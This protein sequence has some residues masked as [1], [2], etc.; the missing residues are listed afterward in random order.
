M[1]MR[2]DKKFLALDMP[3]PQ[4][5]IFLFG[6]PRIVQVG[7]PLKLERRRTLALFAYLAL[8]GPC[9]RDNLVAFFW[10]DSSPDQAGAYLRH[11][12]WEISK[13]IGDGWL[14]KDGPLVG[15]NYAA[16]IWCDAYEI[17][18]L[19]ADNPNLDLSMASRIAALEKDDFL[20]GFTLKD[21]YEFDDWQAAR[22]EWFRQKLSQ[23]LESLAT[24]ESGRGGLED[25][26]VYAH[27]RLALDPLDESSHR[28]LMRILDRSGQRSAAL[29]Q[30]E[31]C[32]RLLNDQ[33]GVTPEAETTLL[34]RQIQAGQ[35]N[36]PE[37]ATRP[38]PLTRPPVPVYLPLQSTPFIGRQSE[39]DQIRAT[40]ANPEC[41]LLVLSGPGGSGKTRLAIQAAGLCAASLAT[42]LFTD[43]IYFCPF[44][45][46]TDPQQIPDR[47]A[48]ALRLQLQRKSLN[49]LNPDQTFEQVRA[50]LSEKSILL[51]IDNFEQLAGQCS[52]LFDLLAAAPNLKII[53][54]S[55]ER[56]NL[57]GEWGLEVAGFPLPGGDQ[58]EAL[59][60]NPAVEMFLKG[61]QRSG[62]FQ[63]AEQDWP[64][65]TRICQLVGGM[66]LGIE[67]ASAW[68]RMFTCS[69]IAAEIE[70]NFD[71]LD[72][73][74]GGKSSLRMAFEQS[75]RLLPAGLQEIFSRLSVFH[76]GFTREA[77]Q[78]VAGAS[79]HHLAA[80]SDRSL[81]RRVSSGR[82]D[83][84]DL[85][86]Q[87][88][89][90]KL[91]LNLA[92]KGL[93]QQRHHLYY[94][95]WICQT[96]E[97]LKGPQ[98][99]AA[100]AA[101]RLEAQNIRSAWDWGI[102]AEKYDHLG[103]AIPMFILFH[104]MHGQKAEGYQAMENLIAGL[105]RFGNPD[106]LAALRTL[107]LAARRHFALGYRQLASDEPD[108]LESLRL[109]YL[110][111]DGYEKAYSFLLNGFGPT[112]SKR[113]QSLDLCCESLAIFKRL[114]DPWGIALATSTVADTAYFSGLDLDL[115][116]QYYAQ[117]H[118]DFTKM[119]NGWGKALACNG[120]GYFAS[121]DGRI[122]EAINYFRDSLEVFQALGDANRLIDIR[123]KLADLHLQ[124]GQASQAL[125]CLRANRDYL[126]QAGQKQ[127][128]EKYVEQIE[129]LENGEPNLV[130]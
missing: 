126:L 65:I 119:E 17:D 5:E 70:R 22:A 80:L 32:Q 68:L 99:V 75:W 35:P 76:G 19:A 130:S 37:R 27:R 98:Q 84:H 71:F 11:A 124:L 12:L 18:R 96:G 79:L 4:L 7:Q 64:A 23:A 24:Y 28:L 110:L 39:Q 1:I 67:L 74:S 81:I 111:P 44:A 117:S 10:P 52:F 102:A 40:L 3:P 125:T 43:G 113:R 57:P 20:K 16:G 45:G 120:L 72:S 61:A 56:L 55:R 48:E 29:R 87:Y 89:A 121:R 105:K 34:H 33:L 128:A 93:T 69:E 91:T 49:T 36:Q 97:L 41:R 25:A 88:A 86:K 62:L 85:L 82:Y 78:A 8:N 108:Q 122:E 31:V 60:S 112:A 21:S 38:T 90:E 94:L 104:E 26:L 115:A 46:V 77:A 42:S 107:A 9:P 109:A 15:L 54:T 118:F 106:D 50:F 58:Q 114:N 100:V 47:L 51:V 6:Y 101:F 14:E 129:N 59:Q 83:L 123:H 53:V 66:P 30:Y 103:R 63:P 116:R 95:D 73:S 92:S 2:I 13:I 127:S